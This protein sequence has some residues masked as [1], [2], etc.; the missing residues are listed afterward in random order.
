[1]AKVFVSSLVTG[2]EDLRD[3]ADGA[4]RTFRH[5]VVRAEEFSASPASPRQACLAAVRSSDVVVVILGAGYGA[6]QESGLSATHE[7]FKEAVD[8]QVP[9]LAF[10]QRGIELEPDQ[11]AFVRD[12]RDWAGGVYTYNFTGVD[13]LR[14][15]VTRALHEWELAQATGPADEAEMLARARELVPSD[16]GGLG[17][18]PDLGLVVV[19]GPRRQVLRPAEI[20][21]VELQEALQQR[22]LFDGRV[23]DPQEGTQPAVEGSA[24]ILR[25]DHASVFLD[26]QGSLR[27][28]QPARTADPRDALPVILHE[29]IQERLDRALRY[30]GWALDKID[31]ARRLSDVVVVAFLTG[32]SHTGW[33]TRAERQREPNSMSV[34]MSGKDVAVVHPTPARRH[35]AAL[36]L[37]AP[38]ISE[39]LA[40]LLRREVRG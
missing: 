7:E 15:E 14:T 16:R 21:S 23:L 6:R 29:E 18:G 8:N 40:V 34:G 2:M 20:E 9:V 4:A 36:A 13:D 35:R 12:V 26:A 30:A 1:M 17:F 39:D 33:K 38:K 22:A 24:L 31:D 11:K 25:Q 27:I 37:E 10:V 28:I 32:A 3:A 19:G 5:E